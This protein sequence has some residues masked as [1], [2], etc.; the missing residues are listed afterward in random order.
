MMRTIIR[1]S[2][3]ETIDTKALLQE[4]YISFLCKSMVEHK[5]DEILLPSGLTIKK[6]FHIIPEDDK[7]TNKND[8]LT[9]SSD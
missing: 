4:S 2:K 7:K 3:D 1:S 9:W 6:S 8:L 5:I